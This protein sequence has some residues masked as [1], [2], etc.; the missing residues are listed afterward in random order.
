MELVFFKPQKMELRFQKS[1]S[2]KI[3]M[4]KVISFVFVRYFQPVFHLLDEIRFCNVPN[5]LW[6]VLVERQMYNHQLIQPFQILDGNVGM[7]I[8]R[9]KF[10]VI[11]SRNLSIIFKNFVVFKMR[12]DNINQFQNVSVNLNL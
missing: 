9:P 1:F 4:R 6:K 5:G 11:N 8:Q 10:I 12:N 7:K 3:R 2:I